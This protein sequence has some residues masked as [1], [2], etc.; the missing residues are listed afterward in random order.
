M[1]LPADIQGAGTTFRTDTFVFG[2]NFSLIVICWWEKV[3]SIYNYP[4]PRVLATSALTVQGDTGLFSQLLM[5]RVDLKPALS[6]V[7]R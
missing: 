5:W 4:S 2:V 1:F 7:T 6:D 3:R